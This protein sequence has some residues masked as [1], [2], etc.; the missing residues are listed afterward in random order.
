MRPAK[1]N[2]P[3]S[4]DGD[5]DGRD[6]DG[7]GG[8]D[9]SLS[10]DFGRLK[11]HVLAAI[12]YLATVAH[13]RRGYATHADG[14]DVAQWGSRRTVV[15]HVANYSAAAMLAE[16]LCPGARHVLDVGCGT[17]AVAGWLAGQLSVPLHLHDRDAAVLA[18]ADRALRPA[19][20][21]TDLAAAPC[22]DVV[23]AME[24]I[25][26][27]ERPAQA[28]FVRQVFSR[29][30]DGGLLV[31]STP[32]ESRYP[33]GTSAYRPHVGTLTLPGLRELLVA[34][35][36][37]HPVVW[38]I[39]GGAF[40]PS[41][42]RRY[43]EWT[44]NHVLPLDLTRKG[45]SRLPRSGPPDGRGGRALDRLCRIRVGTLTDDGTGLIALV[46]K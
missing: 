31:L 45:L 46:L 37:R 1:G 13:L 35:T 28:A 36:G 42:V 21:S 6:L 25:E 29:V 11:D 24:V 4:S 22:A 5:T 39:E 10:L 34:G 12:P 15:R 2:H 16:Q 7:T 18:V 17:A 19:S 27:V 14:G 30:S 44:M 3:T 23:T 43:S 8:R 26:H 38:R 9:G 33:R 41:V 40:S 32:D 20:I